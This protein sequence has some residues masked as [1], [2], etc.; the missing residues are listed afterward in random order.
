MFKINNNFKT[1]SLKKSSVIQ[2]SKISLASKKNQLQPKK[3]EV[4]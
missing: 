1:V 3:Q 4:G 2:T